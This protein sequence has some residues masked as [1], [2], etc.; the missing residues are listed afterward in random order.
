MKPGKQDVEQMVV[1]LMTV[2]HSADR[3]RRKGD[4]SRL[5]ALYVIAALQESSPK[6]ISEELGLH[7]SSVTRQIQTLEQEGHVKVIADPTDGRSCRVKLTTAGRSEIARL[8]AIALRR[9]AGFVADWDVQDVRTL[10]QLLIKFEQSKAATT[11]STKPSGSRWRQ[12][13]K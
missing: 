11:P 3:A 4:A 10:T 12:Q 1:A 2:V 8:Q 5:A 13:E 9:F 7:P 6:A